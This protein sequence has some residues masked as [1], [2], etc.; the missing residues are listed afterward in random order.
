MRE[1]LVTV[2]ADLN[3]VCPTEEKSGNV[4]MGAAEVSEAFRE[5]EGVVETA[6]ADVSSDGGEGDE[7]DVVRIFCVIGVGLGIKA[8]KIGSSGV[9]DVGD[10]MGEGA[11]GLIFESM[12]KVTKEVITA[13]NSKSRWKIFTMRTDGGGFSFL[14]FR[15]AVLVIFYD[16]IFTTIA[17]WGANKIT[18]LAGVGC[19]E[20]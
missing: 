2:G 11:D 6:F 17:K 15:A 9:H 8:G 20:I 12:N 16:V 4:V 3:G 13:V 1:A 18:P 10:G 5:E 14:A 7:I 19:E